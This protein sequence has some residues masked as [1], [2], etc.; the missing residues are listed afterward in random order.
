[1][2]AGEVLSPEARLLFRVA[3]AADGYVALEVRRGAEWTREWPSSPNGAPLRRGE[4][5][6]GDAEGAVAVRV[7][8]GSLEVRL[9]T[10]A[11]PLDGASVV[12]LGPPQRLGKQP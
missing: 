7:G 12:A 5:E 1:V 3:S 4:V 6:L 9:V 8:E 10:A 11:G 2:V